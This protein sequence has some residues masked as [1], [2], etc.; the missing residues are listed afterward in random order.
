MG[1][2][3]AVQGLGAGHHR[4]AEALRSA[5][6][7]PLADR[8]LAPDLAARELTIRACS[9]SPGPETRTGQARTIREHRILILQ[10]RIRQTAIHRKMDLPARRI[11]IPRRAAPGTRMPRAAS[12]A[13]ERLWAGASN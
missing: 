13:G 12:L 7:H 2:V 10:R 6:G 3:R 4:L 9:R 11:Q 8:V 1:L 5:A